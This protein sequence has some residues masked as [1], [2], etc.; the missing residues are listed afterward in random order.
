MG[1]LDLLALAHVFLER[2]VIR[3]LLDE[4]GNILAKARGDDLARHL[5]VL[6]G[7]VEQCGDN[8]V[9]VCAACGLCYQARDLQ[10]VIDVRLGSHPLSAVVKVPARGDIGRFES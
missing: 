10:E 2:F 5:L 8:Q 9:R 1:I 6:N 4:A 3:D 7:V